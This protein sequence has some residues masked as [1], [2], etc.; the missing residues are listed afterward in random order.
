MPNDETI[1]TLGPL[2]LAE[3]AFETAAIMD[4]MLNAKS[5]EE[6]KSSNLYKKFE[7]T[8][9]QGVFI[10]LY[11]RARQDYGFS[12]NRF[13]KIVADT[14]GKTQKSVRN[15]E[16]DHMQTEK[17]ILLLPS[18][19]DK[20]VRVV[21]PT[22]KLYRVMAFHA[23]ISLLLNQDNPHISPDSKVVRFMGDLLEGGIHY[24]ES[25]NTNSI[26]GITAVKLEEAYL[27]ELREA[28]ARSVVYFQTEI[29]K[30]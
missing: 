9:Y 10:Q 4:E 5:R 6:A 8:R 30:S 16:I 19:S 18:A 1:C 7:D 27:E 21:A 22:K 20:R 17:A 15:V 3:A 28:K 11:N 24:H 23:Q 29:E 2:T 14:F 13:D 25:E 12:K 26:E